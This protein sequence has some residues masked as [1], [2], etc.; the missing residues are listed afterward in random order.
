VHKKRKQYKL[1]RDIK[2]VAFMAKKLE[3]TWES[4]DVRP[5]QARQQKYS[6]LLTLRT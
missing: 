2:E 3:T 1:E 5:G 6:N 4:E